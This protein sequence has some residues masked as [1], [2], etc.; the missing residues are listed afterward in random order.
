MAKYKDNL[1]S[2]ERLKLRTSFV[3]YLLFLTDKLRKINSNQKF[4]L[5]QKFSIENTPILLRYRL[6][7]T[8]EDGSKNHFPYYTVMKNHLITKPKKLIHF[9]KIYIRFVS[10]K[11]SKLTIFNFF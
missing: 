11:I 7:Q 4:S 6:C 8:S 10:I 9:T 2:E 5:F 1:T 3:G